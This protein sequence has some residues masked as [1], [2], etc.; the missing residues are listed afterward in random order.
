[1]RK[2]KRGIKKIAA[3]TSKGQTQ[4]GCEILAAAVNKTPTRAIKP[5]NHTANSCIGF[6]ILCGCIFDSGILIVLADN[7]SKH[8]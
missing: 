2:I 6:V 5:T 4:G 7:G 3:M 8:N 1:M